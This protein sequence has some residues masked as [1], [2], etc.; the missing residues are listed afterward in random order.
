MAR[1]GLNEPQPEYL[2]VIL[3]LVSSKFFEGILGGRPKYAHLFIGISGNGK[4][5]RYLD[6]H[7]TYSSIQ[8]SGDLLKRK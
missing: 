6:P 5:L 7:R 1:I 4:S 8:D 2:K 3:K